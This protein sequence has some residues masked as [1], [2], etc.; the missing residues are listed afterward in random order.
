MNG[1]AS[2]TASL[3][4]ETKYTIKATYPDTGNVTGS[5][6]QQPHEV[7]FPPVADMLK[8]KP[9]DED[10]L[11]RFVTAGHGAELDELVKKMPDPPD[12]ATVTAAIEG[13]S[14]SK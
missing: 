9:P 6:A 12:R 5:N 3:L 7:P 10:E 13:A 2:V 8:Q 1:A 4:T 11:K 14:T